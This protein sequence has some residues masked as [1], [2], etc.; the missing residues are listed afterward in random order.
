MPVELKKLIVDIGDRIDTSP[1]CP[2]HWHSVVVKDE[3]VQVDLTPGCGNK[4]RL[5]YVFRNK[6]DGKLLIGQTDTTARKRLYSYHTTF[7]TKR[8]EG[9]KLFPAAVRKNP[10]KFEW[11]VLKELK[12]DESLDNWERAFIIAL[13]TI[14]HGYNQNLGGGGGTCVPKKEVKSDA[15]NKA[16]ESPVKK[17]EELLENSRI[18]DFY[19]D[20]EGFFHADWSPTAK[21]VGSKIYGILLKRDFIYI[22]KTDQELRKRSYQHFSNSRSD[23]EKKDLPLYSEM[24]KSDEGKVLLVENDVNSPERKEGKVRKAFEDAGYKVANVA[25]TGGGG[26]SKIR[27]VLFPTEGGATLSQKT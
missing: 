21:K 11:A 10:D 24:A 1:Y 22:G 13:K 19:K 16:P 2:D 14:A 9:K 23:T 26:A 6:E 25:G 4:K 27:R 8:S 15:E 3:R 12:S 17:A 20:K 7:N 18:Y 5:I